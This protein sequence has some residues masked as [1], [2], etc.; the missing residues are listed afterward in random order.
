MA[1]LPIW[2][3]FCQADDEGGGGEV[4]AGLAAG[5]AEAFDVLALVGE[6]LG[7]AAGE[8]RGRVGVV[9]VIALGLVGQED[10]EAVVQIVGPLGV[11]EGGDEEGGAV[12]LVLEDEVDVAARGRLADG[13]G[14][15]GQEVLFRD[16][17]DGVEAEAVEAVF[18]E[19]VE[20]VLGD[21]V[22]DL[23]AAEVDG[24]TPGGLDVLAEEGFG[25]GVEVA[26]VG[27]EMVVDG[28]R[29]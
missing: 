23:G 29:A 2:S 19:P 9:L 27:A 21:V 20:G 17:V 7:E 11:E 5:V 18:L 8:E 28:R 10:V 13:G 3:W 14:H 24:R 26:A 25:V 4:G 22:A 12:V 1:R 16:G 15:V 6:A